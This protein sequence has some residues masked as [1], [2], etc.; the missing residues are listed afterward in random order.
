LTDRLISGTTI[1][2]ES[3]LETSLRPKRLEDFV[4]QESVK[5]NLDIA[6]Q[7][8]SIRGEPLDHVI[9]YGPPGLGKTTLGLIIAHE[10]EVNIRITSGP[11]IE[12]AGDMAAIL[13]SLTKGDVLFIDEIHRLSR[14]VEEI[15]YSAMEDFFLSWIVGKGLG[16]RNVNLRINPFTLIGATTRYAMVSAPLRDRFG[17]VYHLDYYDPK[18][19]SLIVR[20][21]AHILQV[22]V[23][24]TA[25]DKIANCSRGTPRVA[26]RLL[27]R[28]RDYAQV[29]GN[30]VITERMATEALERLVIDKLGLDEIDIK[31]LTNLIDKFAGGPVGLETL[32]ASISEDPE[33]VMDIYEPFLL[34]LGFLD[35][36]P[37]GRLATN[38]AYSHLNKNPSERRETH[39]GRLI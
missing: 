27:K 23:E 24:D 30:G 11:A 38:A 6:L 34:K 39:P 7:A 9:I 21:S 35:R 20:R 28:T 32:S 4:G 25:V 8:S 12:R 1:P 18:A 37:R 14:V 3:P 19:M 10:M 17:S 2:E 26:N 31:L 5:A 13:T 22:E 33:T 15:L 29:M 16:A 36:T